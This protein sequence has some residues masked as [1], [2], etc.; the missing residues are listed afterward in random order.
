MSEALL[1]R[2]EAR[3]RAAAQPD[4]AP[5][6]EVAASANDDERRDAAAGSDA[7]ARAS[8][9]ARLRFYCVVATSGAVVMALEILASRVLAPAFGNSVYVWGSIISVF[10]AALAVGYRLGGRLADREPSLAALGRLILFAA[11]AEAVLLLAARP[12]VAWLGALTHGSAGGTL[13]AASVLFGP[14]SLLLATVSPYAV[15]LAARD[16]AHLGD[17]AGRLF[18]LSTA[19]SLVGTLGC[20]FVLIPFLE[21]QPLLALLL[22]LTTA[23]A[24]VA[25]GAPRGG[26]RGNAARQQAWSYALA[27]SLAAL[28]IVK[29]WGPE[30][31][32]PLVLYSGITPYQTLAV[33]DL[34]DRRYL[35]SNGM[36]H[37]AVVRATGEPGLAYLRYVGLAALFQPELERALM[38]G[39]GSGAAGGYLQRR[40]PGLAVDYVD[41]DPEVPRL[42]R[43][44]FGFRD[45]PLAR[46]HVDDG[47]RF[48]A[49]STERWDFIY[50]DT[51]IGLSVPFHLTT[52][53]FMREVE[54]HLQPGGVVGMNLAA[55]VDDPYSRAI[56]ATVRYVFPARLFTTRGSGG[57]VLVAGPAV[58]TYLPD[59][60]A[61][62]RELDRR[63]RFDPSL[64]AMLAL[65]KPV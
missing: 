33:G 35:T 21:L 45:G 52:R 44:F 4:A 13:L 51:Y 15:R 40:V 5:P 48:L 31:L 17:T 64:T 27:A 22:G 41:V 61:R 55:G 58:A 50:C 19:G 18:A 11:L 39:M 54:K 20:T 36:L 37:S 60:Q 7:A 53:E 57:M 28:T 59:L 6:L 49:H 65:E 30:K 14:A 32:P 8:A 43:R 56:Y 16:I 25:L 62:A 26:L 46:V 24:V 63:F 42:A 12:L 10:L 47:R 23:T 2:G 1:A 38:I 9:L 3:G 34:D 29:A